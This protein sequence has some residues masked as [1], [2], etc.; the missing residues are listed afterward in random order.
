MGNVLLLKNGFN[1]QH[2]TV[3]NHVFNIE[4]G[5]HGYWIAIQRYQNPKAKIL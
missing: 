1:G 3:A 5:S 2:T 4:N